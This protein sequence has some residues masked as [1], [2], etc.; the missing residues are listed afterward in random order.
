MDTRN[1]NI[2]PKETVEELRAR[3]NPSVNFF[4]LIP[5]EFEQELLAMNRQQRREWYR[6]NKKL[7]MNPNG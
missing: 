2:V 3:K 4:K 1:F 7:L 5:K 6:K